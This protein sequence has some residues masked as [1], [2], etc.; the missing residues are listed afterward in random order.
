MDR[1]AIVELGDTL[2]DIDVELTKFVIGLLAAWEDAEEED[3]CFGAA[4]A[5]E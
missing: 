4:L 5:D 2:I 3:F 1:F